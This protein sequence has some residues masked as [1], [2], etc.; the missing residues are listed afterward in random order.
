MTQITKNKFRRATESVKACGIFI[1]IAQRP[2]WRK[3]WNVW[4]RV[5]VNLLQQVSGDLEVLVRMTLPLPSVGWT[6]QGEVDDIFSVTS[7]SMSPDLGDLWKY[8]CAKCPDWDS[9]IDVWTEGEEFSEDFTRN[10]R[11]VWVGLCWEGI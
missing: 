3:R 1:L 4:N 7:G 5:R 11:Q 2:L 6:F 9:D 8:G 10:L